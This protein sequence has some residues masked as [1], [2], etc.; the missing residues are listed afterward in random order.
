MELYKWI[1]WKKKLAKKYDQI[2]DE[3]NRI[4]FPEGM[5]SGFY[6]YIVF[7]VN[8]SQKTGPVFGDLCH[9]HM[10]VSGDFLNSEWVKDHHFCPPIYFGWE[11]ANKSCEELEKLLVID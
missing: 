7:D 10:K 1:D 4:V 6:K 8:L 5:E 2:F 3:K 9:D 11:E